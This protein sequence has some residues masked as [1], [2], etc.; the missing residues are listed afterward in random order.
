MSPLPPSPLPL[1]DDALLQAFE[2]TSISAQDFHHSEHVRVVWKLIEEVGQ[3]PARERF[4]GALVRLAKAH[5]ADRL[6]H[7][8]LTRAWVELIAE[9]ARRSPSL[10][11]SDEFL[12]SHPELLDRSILHRFYSPELLATEEARTGW[13]APDRLPIASGA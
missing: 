2:T 13:V 3:E 11:T 8:T 7:E 1:D 10:A 6:Y 4:V 9:A 12:S 5:G